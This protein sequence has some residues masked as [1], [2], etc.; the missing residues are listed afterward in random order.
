MGGLQELKFACGF[1]GA[2]LAPC[3]WTDAEEDKTTD[4][5]LQY[6]FQCCDLDGDGRL[7]PSELMVRGLLCCWH[8]SWTS[9]PGLLRGL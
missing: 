3:F 8:A 2:H 1:Y 9:R 6:W 7:T 4:A 5:S